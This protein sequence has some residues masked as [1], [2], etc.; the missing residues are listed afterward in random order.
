MQK[1]KNM[2]D[3]ETKLLYALLHAKYYY[4]SGVLRFRPKWDEAGK[5]DRYN[6]EIA[7]SLNH[8][9]YIVLT[10]AEGIQVR[11]SRAIFLMHHGYLPESVDHDNRIRTDDRIENLVSSN[12]LEQANN[13]GD[14]K[15][16]RSG[17]QNIKQLYNGAWRVQIRRRGQ[18]FDKCFK[19]LEDAIA[20]RNSFIENLAS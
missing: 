9:G 3:R 13:R 17:H 11:R 1:E 4:D 5:P 14:R 18:K 10:V 16:N 15:D 6:N 20:A 8:D 19:T 7:G 12:A 2:I